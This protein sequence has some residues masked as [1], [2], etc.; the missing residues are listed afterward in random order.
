MARWRQD[1]DEIGCDSLAALVAWRGLDRLAGQ[2]EGHEIAPPLMVGDAIAA[3]AD[4]QDVES[5]PSQLFAGR[6]SP[7]SRPI[8]FFTGGCMISSRWPAGSTPR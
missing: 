1:F 3:G 4:L 5:H 7:T 6:I 8:T 2:R